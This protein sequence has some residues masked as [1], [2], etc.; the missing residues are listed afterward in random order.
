M[1]KIWVVDDDLNLANLTKVA[2]VKKGHEVMI[3]HEALKAIEEAKK[4]KPDLILMDI[5][6]PGV[7]GAEAVKELRKDP[8]LAEMPVIFLTGLIGNEEE[9]VE[10]KGIN[11]DGV[12]YKTL[13]KPYEIKQLLE[14]VGNVVGLR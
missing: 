5:M 10:N 8:N 6:L 7:S 13:G 12:N 4:R 9:G 3:F 2:L 1:A 11:I 14:L